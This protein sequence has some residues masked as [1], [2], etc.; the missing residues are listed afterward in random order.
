MKKALAGR[1]K[2]KKWKKDM[3]GWPLHPTVRSLSSLFSLPGGKVRIMPPGNKEK[4]KKKG[5]EEIARGPHVFIR[6][7]AGSSFLLPARHRIKTVDQRS[8]LLNTFHHLW[9]W[10]DDERWGKEK[11]GWLERNRKRQRKRKLE[12]TFISFPFFFLW[13][14]PGSGQ[15]FF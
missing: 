10:R 3:P 5:K 14:L 15:C 12:P 2:E 9:T 1:T 11:E 13:V 8:S 6:L 7:A 4:R